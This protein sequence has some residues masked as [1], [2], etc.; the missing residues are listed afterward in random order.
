MIVII[1]KNAL[2]FSIIY[3][4]TITNYD[5]KRNKFL[6]RSFF[7]QIFIEVFVLCLFE[8]C[9][10]VFVAS[11]FYFEAFLSPVLLR[12]YFTLLSSLSLCAGKT[13]SSNF[14]IYIY[15]VYTYIPHQANRYRKVI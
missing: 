4:D 14:T 11:R 10:T 6:S 8:L 2:F 12:V 9:A 15:T 7:F 1:D 13:C 5:E 3:I